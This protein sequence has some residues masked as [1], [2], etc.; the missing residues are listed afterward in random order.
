MIIRTNTSP[1]SEE[2]KTEEIFFRRRLE[3]YRARERNLQDHI[4]KLEN[5]VAI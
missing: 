1:V 5:K 2:R 3:E 4:T